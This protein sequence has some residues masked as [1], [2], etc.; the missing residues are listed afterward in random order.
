[1]A[2][3]IAVGKRLKINKAQQNMLLAVAGA[4]FVLGV[5][6]VFSVYFLKYIR[7]NSAVI[8]E[9]DIAIKGYSDAIRDIGICRNPSGS[10]YNTAELNGCEPN[11]VDLNSVT[12][13]LRYNIINGVSQNKALES[14]ARTGLPICY[15]T[16]TGK[17][18]SFDEIYDNYRYAKNATDKENYLN[19]IGMCSSLRVIPDA[20]PSSP[21]PLALGASLNKIFAISNYDPDGITP[22]R[23]TESGALPGIGA[24]DLTLSIDSDPTTTMKVLLNMEKSIRSINILNA[25]IESNSISLKLD[26]SAVAY[27]TEPVSLTE[28]IVVVNGDGTVNKDGVEEVVEE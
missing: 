10:V 12:E 25:K 19:M 20:L 15:D 11:E 4:S 6:L 26:A 21:N 14:V 16:S 3:N 9:K 22:G 18:Y 28:S 24:I 2:K 17:K 5:C 1:M 8:R 7:F 23:T 13:S 27:Y